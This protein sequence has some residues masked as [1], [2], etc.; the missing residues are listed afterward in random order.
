MAGT[1]TFIPVIGYPVDGGAGVRL[2]M[3]RA[4]LPGGFPAYARVVRP[5]DLD[6]KRE[7]PVRWCTMASSFSHNK[8]TSP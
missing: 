6:D 7:R 4:L 1:T 3:L 2:W 5:A 8:S